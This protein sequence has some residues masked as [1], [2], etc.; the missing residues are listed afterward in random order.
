M[1]RR[2]VVTGGSAITPIGQGWPAIEKR[3]R[4]KRS[5][6]VS[7]PDWERFARLHTRLAA[8][9]LGMHLGMPSAHVV[10]TGNTSRDGYDMLVNAFGPGAAAPAGGS[11]ARSRPCWRC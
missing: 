7:M 10:D 6:V 2:V 11:P 4:E 8:P 3:L 9:A 5:G 1:T